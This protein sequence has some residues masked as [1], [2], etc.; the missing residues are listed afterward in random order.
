[1]TA[2]TA[3]SNGTVER[4]RPFNTPYFDRLGDRGVN[5]AERCRPLNWR[6]R[7]AVDAMTYTKPVVAALAGLVLL[8]GAGTAVATP[9]EAGSDAGPPADAGPPSDLPGPVP[10]F[11]GEVLG[12]VNG[13]LSGSID[14]LGEAVSGLTPGGEAAGDA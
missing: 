4:F 5:A 9:G 2:A 7:Q 11:V 12:A 6:A 14:A 10:D 1:V 3:G 8:A 13:F